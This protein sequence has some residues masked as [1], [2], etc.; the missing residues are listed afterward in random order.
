MLLRAACGSGV[1]RPP[2]SWTP[3]AVAVFEGSVLLWIALGRHACGLSVWALRV[4]G[5]CY[6]P[7]EP[8]VRRGPLAL[9]PRGSVWRGLPPGKW[10]PDR[11]GVVSD[12]GLWDAEGCS[13]VP[14]RMQLVSVIWGIGPHLC[15]EA[16]GHIPPLA[17]VFHGELQGTI[18]LHGG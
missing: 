15:H 8:M 16:G 11:P 14:S 12:Q 2:S 9:V 5:A 10:G 4:A 1:G 13:V 18:A 7:R 3:A 6:L 17:G